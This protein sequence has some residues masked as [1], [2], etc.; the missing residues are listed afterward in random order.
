MTNQNL[1]NHIINDAADIAVAITT[2]AAWEIW[3]QVEL[4]ILLRQAGLQVAREVPYPAPNQNWRLD[5]LVQDNLGRYAIELKVESANNAGAAV[6]PSIQHDINKI[7]NYTDPHRFRWV[8]GI[9]YSQ[10]ARNALSQFANN[11]ANNAIY[12]ADQGHDIG[13][14][15]VTV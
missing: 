15:V 1:L 13:V 6:L 10:V 14:I 11:P 5:A 8:L 9:A 7:G 2:G 12:F 3:M 4:V